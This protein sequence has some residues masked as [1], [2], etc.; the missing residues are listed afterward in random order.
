MGAPWGQVWVLLSPSA[1]TQY[2]AGQGAS[3]QKHLLR[4][5]SR[6]K[7]TEVS[8][9]D[10]ALSLVLPECCLWLTK[11]GTVMAATP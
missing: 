7:A 1:S 4:D 6:V 10:V 8:D 3:V 11:S 5:H 9:P 2:T